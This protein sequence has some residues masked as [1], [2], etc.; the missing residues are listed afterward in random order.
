MIKIFDAYASRKGFVP[1]VLQFFF[2][3]VRINAD[4]TPTQL[5]MDDRDR[6]YVYAAEQDDAAPEGK[7]ARGG[8]GVC[9]SA[10]RCVV[11]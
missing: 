9:A 7:D 10:R 5:E 4:Q 11:S 6:V 1:S 2:N 3:D 8:D